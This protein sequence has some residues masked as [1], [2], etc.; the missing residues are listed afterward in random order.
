MEINSHETYKNVRLGTTVDY[1]G[2]YWYQCVDQARD[3][4]R[5]VWKSPCTAF[6]GTAYIGWLR[7]EQVFP[8][9]QSVS[10]FATVPVGSLVIFKPYATVRVKRPW[11]FLWKKT[12]LTSAW[13]VAV[14][15]Y[16][17]D[18]W[19]IRVI[20]QN[21]ATGNG[22]GKGGNAIR[23]RWYKWKDAVAG[24]ILQ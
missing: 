17:D 12:K 7:R 20:E 9:H 2:V 23:L 13:H 24:F 1:D 19:V 11:A 3:Y 21:G 14:V 15:D 6:G 5:S 16:T 22:D 18:S 10:W 4:C 8:W